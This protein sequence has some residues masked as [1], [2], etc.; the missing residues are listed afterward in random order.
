MS[1][2]A[3]GAGRRVELTGLRRG[4]V[5]SM[6][7]S[8]VVPQFTL[9]RDVP[10]AGLRGLR[11]ALK[12]GGHGATLTDVITMACARALREHPAVNS[13]YGDDC[14]IEHERVN[15][16][17]ALALEDGL[18]VPVILDADRRTLEGLSGERLRLAEAARTRSLRPEEIFAGTFSI[19][20]LG[21][22]GVDRFQALVLPPQAA[23]LAVG[24]LRDS[25]S[26]SASFDHRAVD[27]APGARFL[28]TIARLLAEPAW[29]LGSQ[30]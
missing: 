25:V 9:Q 21:P 24:S 20:N 30:G 17:L 23:I 27:G 13:S 4:T 18:T 22:L 1:D 19:S 10:T 29:A 8:A 11:R 2:A 14:V 16:G 3:R 15:I 6:S 12:S 28:A 5:R 26:L 7:V